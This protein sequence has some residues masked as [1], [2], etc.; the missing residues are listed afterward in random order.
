M[1]DHSAALG[2]GAVALASGWVLAPG[3]AVTSTRWCAMSEEEL[4]RQVELA[5]HGDADA[6]QRLIVHHHAALRRAVAPIVDRSLRRYVDPDDV[7]QEAYI[8]AFKNIPGT[9]FDSQDH[10]Y[11]WLK[12]IARV[13]LKAESLCLETPTARFSLPGRYGTASAAHASRTHRDATSFSLG[14]SRQIHRA[15]IGG[16]AQRA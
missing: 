12:R 9:E 5:A 10:F 6:L 1:M 11:N 3:I 8:S 7:L 16:P 14:A 2:F 13:R 4:G 15:K